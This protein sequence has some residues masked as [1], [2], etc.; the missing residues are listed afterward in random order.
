MQQATFLQLQLQVATKLT[1]KWRSSS[2]ARPRCLYVGR[3]R[4]SGRTVH[5]GLAPAIVRTPSPG[6]TSTLL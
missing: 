2:G 1:K 3:Y 4:S 6:F 5:P